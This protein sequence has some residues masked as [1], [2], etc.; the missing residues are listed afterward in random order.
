[1]YTKLY[2]HIYKTIYK[3]LFTYSHIY[4]LTIHR[5]IRARGRVDG[6][7][8]TSKRLKGP[9]IILLKSFTSH[10]SG[11]LPHSGPHIV[12][13]EFDEQVEPVDSEPS[14]HLFVVDATD[15]E[16]RME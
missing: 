6:R 14:P 9:A 3:S 11:N 7:D 8:K 4:I 1:M 12:Y 13:R 15:T 5:F 16:S 10:A 2:K